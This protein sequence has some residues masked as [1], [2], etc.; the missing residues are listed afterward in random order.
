[1]LALF[2]FQGVNDMK[3]RK[4]SR[5]NIASFHLSRATDSSKESKN[6][7]LTLLYARAL[8]AHP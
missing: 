5:F 3:R 8:F 7:F 4:A 6:N 2:L 1:M